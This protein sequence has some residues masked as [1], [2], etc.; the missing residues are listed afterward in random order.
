MKSDIARPLNT[1]DGVS[2]VIGVDIINE[3][4]LFEF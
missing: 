4:E 3:T 1:R 2:A